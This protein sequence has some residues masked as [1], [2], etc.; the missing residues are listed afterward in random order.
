[1]QAAALNQEGTVNGPS[2]P[3]APG[4]VIALFGAGYGSLIPPCAIG[5]LPPGA[6][7]THLCGVVQ[8]NFQVR[9]DALFGPFRPTPP[10][11]R[12]GHCLLEP[13][14]KTEGIEVTAEPALR[15]G[16]GAPELGDVYRVPPSE[17]DL[18]SRHA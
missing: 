2:N 7:A 1:M 16:R 3:A 5:V 15:F 17:R 18:C 12:M 13:I 11:K 14:G 9:F 6:A 10:K 4:S 8:F